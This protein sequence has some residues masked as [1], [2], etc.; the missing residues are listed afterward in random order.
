MVKNENTNNLPSEEQVEKFR[1]LSKLINSI[2]SELKEFAKKK[3]DEA[4]NKFK[5]KTI[6]RVLEQ[7]KDIL[8]SEPTSDFLDLLDEETIPSN[9][10]AVLIIGQFKAAME[11]FKNTYYRSDGLSFSH[12]WI[13]KEN[14]E[15]EPEYEEDDEDN[16]EDQG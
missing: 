2:Y 15:Y 7:I 9:S 8:S 3:P 16:D 12:R 4:L 1:M 6:N 11:Q 5:I 14:P 10:D 13:T